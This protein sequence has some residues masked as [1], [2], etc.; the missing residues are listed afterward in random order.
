MKS[1]SD[2]RT[3]NVERIQRNIDSTLR[4]MELANE[5]IEKT[6][7]SKLIKDLEDK[8][9]RRERALKGLRSEIQDE[10]KDRA[11]GYRD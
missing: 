4:N 2:N 5:L 10:A 11:K 1:K 8:N 7:D 3:D 6:P 9:D